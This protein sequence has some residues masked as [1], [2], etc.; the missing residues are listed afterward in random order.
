MCKKLKNGRSWVDKRVSEMMTGLVDNL[1]KLQPLFGCV[2]RRIELREE[3]KVPK[4][5]VK[6]K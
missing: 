1:D 3:K 2:E 4:H 6:K 5:Y